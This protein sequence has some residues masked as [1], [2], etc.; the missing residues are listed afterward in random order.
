MTYHKIYCDSEHCLVSDNCARHKSNVL[1][2]KPITTQPF[3]VD[4]ECESYDPIEEEV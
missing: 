4:G 3:D 1:S 2:D